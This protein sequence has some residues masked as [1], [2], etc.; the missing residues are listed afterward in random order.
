MNGTSIALYI[1]FSFGIP[2]KMFGEIILW[3]WPAWKV[4]SSSGCAADSAPRY[5]VYFKTWSLFQPHPET[6]FNF[7]TNDNLYN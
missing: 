6:A 2:I 4:G 5:T 1:L 3:F 7:S